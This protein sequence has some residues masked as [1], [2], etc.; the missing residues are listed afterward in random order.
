MSD[1]FDD[2]YEEY[3]DSYGALEVPVA[4]NA[5]DQDDLIAGVQGDEDGLASAQDDEGQPP[6]NRRKI[7]FGVIFVLFILPLLCFLCIFLFGSAAIV[8]ALFSGEGVVLSE[9][10]EP[11]ATAIAT[12]VPT[13]A[14]IIAPTNTPEPT[15]T[16]TMSPPS[17][18]FL[19]PENNAQIT[20]GE[21]I[22]IVVEVSD[23]NGITS[24]SI[25][26][27]GVSPKTFS[28]ETEVTFRERWSPE[29][30]GQYTFTVILRSRASN[31]PITLEGITLTVV[32]GDE[33]TNDSENDEEGSSDG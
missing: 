20:L 10:G 31:T 33:D 8:P 15:P 9:E 12:F 24:L 11:E 2:Y 32:T 6:S 16:P 23:P 21:S 7:I 28:G 3:D 30:P 26:G 13:A 27:S 17:A 5:W 14:V 4:E 1:N 19:S 22:E 25:A 29:N 18:T